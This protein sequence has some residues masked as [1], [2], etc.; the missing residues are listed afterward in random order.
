[1][2]TKTLFLILYRIVP[3]IILLHLFILNITGHS[4]MLQVFNQL[5]VSS[6]GRTIIGVVELGAALLLLHPKLFWMGAL[7]GLGLMIA[8]IFSHLL[9]LGIE[10]DSDC[11]LLFGMAVIVFITCLNALWMDSEKVPFLRTLIL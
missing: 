1:M 7:S 5:G 11:G 4:E 10:I 8:M 9:I 3:A 6:L 2:Y